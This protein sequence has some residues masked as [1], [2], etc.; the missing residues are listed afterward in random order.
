MGMTS[1]SPEYKIGLW[2][3]Q[4]ESVKLCCAICMQIDETGLK[5]FTVKSNH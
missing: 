2:C 4:F 3:V 1:G 5:M